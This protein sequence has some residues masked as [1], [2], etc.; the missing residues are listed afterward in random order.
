[1]NSHR[2]PPL[3]I[4]LLVVSLVAL[5][6][7]VPLAGQ[8]PERPPEPAGPRTDVPIH[9]PVIIREGGL[10]T[11]FA[12]GRGISVW[13]SPDLVHWTRGDP[14]FAGPPAWAVEAVPTFKG[15]IWAPDIAFHDGT[16]FLYYSVSAFGK[17]TSCIGV[18]TNTTLDPRNPAFQWVDH[19]KVV[20][21]IPGLTNWNAIDPNII[22]DDDGT[23]WMSFGSFWDGLKI[24][25]LRPDRLGLAE[26][27]SPDDLP[28]I[29]SRKTEPDAANPPAPPGNPEDAGGNAIEAPFIF[30]HGGWYHL[31]VS[32]DYCCRGKN[33]TY[34]MIVGRSKSA[35]G[36]F[37]DRDGVDLARGGGT[38]LLAGDDRWYGVG[39]NSVASFDG[40]DYLVFHAYDAKDER[41]RSKLRIHKLAWDADGWPS[42]GE[43]VLPVPSG[44]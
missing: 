22:T 3:L 30:R 31:F 18:A 42:V 35:T 38:M 17:N 21:S 43:A 4:R 13:T 29:A 39:H 34:K 1:M 27:A 6:T 36:P 32:I 44:R 11:I 40:V 2:V 15:H 12:T 24:V 26:G 28:T 7:G 14:V 37:V 33:S 19:G 41:G 25:K 16:Y 9:D 5:A 8:D 20:E 23:A 10:Y